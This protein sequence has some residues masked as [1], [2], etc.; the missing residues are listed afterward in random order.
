MSG[1]SG[2]A[3]GV[4]R[5]VQY[6]PVAESQQ[7]SRDPEGFNTES[8][9]SII[10]NEFVKAMDEPQSTFSIDVDNA[11][12][13]NIRRMLQSGSL[14]PKDAVRLEEMINFFTYSYPQPHGE[15][16]FSF[17]TELGNC[18]WNSQHKIIRIGMQGKSI[19]TNQLPSMN[20]VF[21]LDVSGS[22]NSPNKLP[23]LK[24]SL[25]N[26]CRYLRPQDKISIV[27][28]AGAAGMV[29]SASEPLW[30][31]SPQS[32]PSCRPWRPMAWWCWDS[33]GSAAC[34]GSQPRGA[35]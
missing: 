2:D 14:P 21:L 24:K 9:D 32:G 27:V 25:L 20:L 35:G 11:S 18:P 31:A 15:H 4:G 10:E 12:Y 23:L 19:P 16:P 13:T 3:S 29:H 6:V 7:A 8:Y 34:C 22:M 28:Y 17:T 26:L 30:S 5:S 33:R 1:C